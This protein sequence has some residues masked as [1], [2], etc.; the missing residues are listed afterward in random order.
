MEKEYALSEVEAA[1]ASMEELAML[2]DDVMEEDAAHQILVSRWQ[3]I[4]RGWE[5]DLH[6]GSWYSWDEAKG[7]FT[8]DFSVTI[9]KEHGKTGYLYWEQD[10]FLSAMANYMRQRFDLEAMDMKSLGQL[11]CLIQV[12]ED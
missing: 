6:E 4:I 1:V 11:M 9:I 5:L 7:C 12:P 8:A 10:G 3:P 2:D